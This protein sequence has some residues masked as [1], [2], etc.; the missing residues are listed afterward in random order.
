MMHLQQEQQ[1]LKGHGDFMQSE[2]YR[3]NSVP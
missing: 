2:H 1:Q 3:P